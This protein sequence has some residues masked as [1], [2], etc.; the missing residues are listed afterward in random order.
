ML[1]K[2]NIVK[3]TQHGYRGVIYKAF[4]SWEDLKTKQNF[5]TIDPDNESEKMDKIEKLIQGDPKDAW[6]EAQSIPFTD[7]QL[8]ENWYSVRCFDGGEIW[9]CESLLELARD[10]RLN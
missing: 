9:T 3:A 5:I 7:E 8:K 4:T 10:S 6:L 2:G 1:Q